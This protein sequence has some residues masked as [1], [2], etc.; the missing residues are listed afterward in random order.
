[1]QYT[2]ESG[3]LQGRN[4]RQ[5]AAV[6]RP[7]IRSVTLRFI[8]VEMPVILC[9]SDTRVGAVPYKS[10]FSVGAT[11]GVRSVFSS[12]PIG[13]LKAISSTQV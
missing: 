12:V 4:K 6:S 2:T 10:F 7:F 8:I 1:M 13:S 3:E 5:N 11:Y 9:T